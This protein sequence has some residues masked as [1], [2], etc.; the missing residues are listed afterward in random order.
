MP[1]LGLAAKLTGSQAIPSTATGAPAA[2]FGLKPPTA[3]PFDLLIW[4]TLELTAH[5]ANGGTIRLVDLENAR[6]DGACNEQVRP[7]DHQAIDAARPL[8]CGRTAIR[9][10][11]GTGRAEMEDCPLVRWR[12]VNRLV[13]R[14]PRQPIAGAPTQIGRKQRCGCDIRSRA[15]GDRDRDREDLGLDKRELTIIHYDVAAA[16]HVALVGPRGERQPAARR[17][18]AGRDTCHD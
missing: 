13:A 1:A 11:L 12:Q 15:T 16:K 6:T 5:G 2:F 8:T 9:G 7:G 4:K 17:G 3:A 10:Q 18:C 14:I